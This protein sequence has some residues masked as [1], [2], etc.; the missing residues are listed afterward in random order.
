VTDG[1]RSDVRD[2]LLA[3][4]IACV[5]VAALAG[6]G[7]A[8]PFVGR[9]LGALV[10]VV[11]LY[12]P[13]YFGWRRKEELAEYGFR[14]DPLG[15]GLLIGFGVPL[16]IFPLFAVLFVYFYDFVCRPGQ[17]AWLRQLAMP[18]SCQRFRGW[19]GIRAPAIDLD[20]L[21]LAFV[22]VVVIALP[23]ELFFRGFIHELLERA[24]PPRRRLWGGGI[25]WALV[26][27]SALF[28]AGH[29]AAG[30]DPRRLAVFFP[31]LLFGWMRSATGS[32]LAGTIAHA[33]SNL[34]I[35]VLERMFL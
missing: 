21:E 19:A 29:L 27:S 14:R 18:G 10:A 28:A 1:G 26:L 2:A 3:F 24:M 25:G 32:I 4:A 5:G 20:L 11:F 22:Q 33:A 9:N 13:V 35:H 34:Y 31:G 15:K 7:R 6:L 30:L 17:E 16:L 23:E 8:V 12:L